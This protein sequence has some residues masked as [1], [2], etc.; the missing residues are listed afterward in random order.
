[1]VSSSSEKPSGL[2]PITPVLACDH[3]AIAPRMALVF[4]S[5]P[6]NGRVASSTRLSSGSTDGATPFSGSYQWRMATFLPT[7]EALR[8]I[9]KALDRDPSDPVVLQ[10]FDVMVL[11]GNLKPFRPG[12]WE[13][14]R[15][16]DHQLREIAWR[17]GR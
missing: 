15:L 1:M 2:P 3:R 7:A 11:R 13:V 12:W 4:Q 10:V 9:A 6:R 17:N 5:L 8:Q 14:E 16:T